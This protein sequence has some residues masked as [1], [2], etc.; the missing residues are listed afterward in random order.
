MSVGLSVA[1]GSVKK[2]G[3]GATVT[4]CPAELLP[5]SS[6]LLDDLSSFPLVGELEGESVAEAVAE[7][8]VKTGGGGTI[9]DDVALEATGE[10]VGE[11]ADESVGESHAGR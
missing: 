9:E 7:G 5:G 1:E 3:G 10:A 2:G 4:D 6:L 8:T 11:L